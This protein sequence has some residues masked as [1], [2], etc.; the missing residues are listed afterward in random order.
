[1]VLICATE[2]RHIH[3]QGVVHR[4]LKPENILLDAGGTLKVSDFGL[5][6]VWHIQASGKTRQLT[7]VCGSLPY[8][9]PEVRFKVPPNS[10]S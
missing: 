5:A 10:R 7:D 8:I 2:Q 3:E 6:A 4:D 1:M 9:A